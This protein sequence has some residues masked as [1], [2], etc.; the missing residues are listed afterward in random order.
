MPPT[1]L[2]AGILLVVAGL[3]GIVF[4]NFERRVVIA[5]TA[6]ITV[7]FLLLTCA[8]TT[9]W[10]T[11]SAR[12]GP[13]RP[14]EEQLRTFLLLG[15]AMLGLF[16]SVSL[17]AQVVGRERAE[18]LHRQLRS[19]T[20][21][22]VFSQHRLSLAGTGVQVVEQPPGSRYRHRY[23]GLYLLA[24]ARGRYFL[25]PVGWSKGRD[26]AMV[27]TEDDGIRLDFRAPFARRRRL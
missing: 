27:I 13:V 17:Y 14:I 11:R 6:S 7:G 26:T 8:N 21:V 12:R 10:R 23:S 16:W 9:W 5:L 2:G 1:L 3:A 4:E 19:R 25:L 15:L 18:T 20:E 24:E 22:V